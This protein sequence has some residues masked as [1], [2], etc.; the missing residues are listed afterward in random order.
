MHIPF[1]ETSAKNGT[2]VEQAFLTLAAEIKARLEPSI[3]ADKKAH[4]KSPG[5]SEAQGKIETKSK[6]EVKA[7][8][9]QSSPSQPEPKTTKPDGISFTDMLATTRRRGWLEKRGHV[10]KTWRSRY[11]VLTAEVRVL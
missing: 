3:E 5:K 9:P 8:K 4:A 10:H 6:P 11:F 7:P 2:N 1:L